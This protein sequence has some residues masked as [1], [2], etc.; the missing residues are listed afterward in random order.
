MAQQLDLE[1]ERLDPNLTSAFR[2]I[3]Y[4]AS[5]YKGEKGTDLTAL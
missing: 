4:S 2:H 1:A 3:T 5:M